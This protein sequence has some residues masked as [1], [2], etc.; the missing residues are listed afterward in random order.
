MLLS[1]LVWRPWCSFGPHEISYG[2]CWGHFELLSNDI[3]FGGGAAVKFSNMV[4]IKFHNCALLVA[5]A[6]FESA[7]QI[8]EAEAFKKNQGL[9][10]GSTDPSGCLT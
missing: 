5:T 4:R 8:Q 10:P 3:G 9:R 2:I 7:T 1:A 6:D